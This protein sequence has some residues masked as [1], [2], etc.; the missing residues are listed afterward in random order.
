MPRT[1]ILLLVITALMF[2]MAGCDSQAS[3]QAEA[4]RHLEA[5]RAKLN[6]ANAG[7]IAHADE[8][9]PR[10]EGLLVYRQET[11]DAAFEDLNK[12]LSLDAPLQKIQAYRLCADIDASAAQHAAREAAIENA[13]ISGRSTVLLG[14]LSAMEGSST[15]ADALQ[16]QTE[17]Q[18]AKLQDEIAT[19]TTRQSSVSAEVDDLDNQLLAVTAEVDQF[20]ARADEGYAQAQ[21]KREQAFIATGDAMYNL[22]DQAADLDRKAAIESASAEQRQVHVDDLS[23]RLT[24]SRIELDTVN[25]L[26]AELSE[27]VSSTRADTERLADESSAAAQDSDHAAKILSDEYKQITDVYAEAVE[28]RMKLASEKA[29][30][31]VESLQQASNIT[32]AAPDRKSIKLQLLSAY[33][34]QAHIATSHAAYVRDLSNT[35]RAVLSS[36]GGISPQGTEQYT[37]QLNTLTDTHTALRDKADAAIEAGQALADELAPEGSTAEDG[38]TEA[39]ALQQIARLEKYKAKL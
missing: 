25:K 7:Y 9:N 35:T 30:K 2:S 19:Q 36:V 31:V 39:I 33:V 27:Q 20:K 37:T 32:E 23:G 4:Q 24:L 10:P 38:D 1:P 5:A 6:Q 15:R 11:M 29:D 8:Q 17:E 14:Y 12:V 13:A 28:K 34:D 16:P 22:Q 26:L 21:A 3:Q 18:I